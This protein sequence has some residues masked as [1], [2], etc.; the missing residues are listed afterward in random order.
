MKA[1][2]T[3]IA[4]AV[5]GVMA[6]S[7]AT[8]AFAALN[9][10]TVDSTSKVSASGASSV[11]GQRTVLVV[12]KGSWNAVT[13]KL[14]DNPVIVYINQVDNADLSNTLA[15]M[16]GKNLTLGDYVVLV[17][18]ENGTIESDNFTAIKVVANQE[19]GT[20]LSWEVTMNS[21]LLQANG[22]VAKF[23]DKTSSEAVGDPTTL[24]WEDGV[25][26]GDGDF[27]FTAETTV[28]SDD[29]AGNTGLEISAGTVSGK[30]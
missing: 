26:T 9:V 13:N 7:F 30:N 14:I 4:S 10:G 5:A 29:Y 12:A 20:N 17:G 3:F 21:N 8:S 22:V 15:A 23:Y 11:A 2:K 25:I 18:N 1:F 16:A 24:W 6:L 28:S 19:D 27:T